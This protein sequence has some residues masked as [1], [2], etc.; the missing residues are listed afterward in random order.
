VV[1][2]SAMVDLL[3]GDPTWVE[4]LGH[5]QSRHAMLLAPAH[6]Q[7]EVANALMLRVRLQPADAIARLRELSSAGVGIADRGLVGIFDAIELAARHGLT[8]YDAAYLA[9][10][11]DIDAELAT[12]DHA[13]E[14]AA[15]EEGLTVIA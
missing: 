5:W 9:L 15:R 14:R 8:V 3:L 11:L 1:D 6:F 2:A 13:L 4:R 12:Q 10:A 7:A